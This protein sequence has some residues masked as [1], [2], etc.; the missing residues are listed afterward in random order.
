VYT[1][2]MMR[3]PPTYAPMMSCLF[4]GLLMCSFFLC[5]A[6]YMFHPYIQTNHRV[7]WRSSAIDVPT[8]ESLV[9]ANDFIVSVVFVQHTHTHTHV[10]TYILH[11]HSPSFREGV[12]ICAFVC[13]RVCIWCCF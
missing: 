7:F 9:P 5:G 12:C 4:L 11:I 2:W 13:V 8:V 1:H 6:D 10:H 3:L